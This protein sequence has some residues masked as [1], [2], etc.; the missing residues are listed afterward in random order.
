MEIKALSH[1]KH[2]ADKII[3]TT[4]TP[5]RALGQIIEGF[6]SKDTS[7]KP[8]QLEI[9]VLSFGF[10]HGPPEEADLIVDVRFLSNPHNDPALRPLTGRDPQVRQ[11]VLE[12]EAANQFLEHYMTL[13]KFLIPRYQN[14]GKFYLTLGI[15]CTGGQH[16]SVAISEEVRR[17]LTELNYSCHLIHRDMG[18]TG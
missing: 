9:T 16:R 10:F 5:P 3:N 13:L 6:L 15:G 8:V 2:H 17:L 4:R 14:E 7:L 18:N 1:I 12:Q 11:F